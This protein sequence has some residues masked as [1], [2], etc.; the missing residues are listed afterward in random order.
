[1]ASRN[2]KPTAEKSSGGSQAKPSADHRGAP[3]GKG[4]AS[5]RAAGTGS[6]RK[7]SSRKGGMQG[8]QVTD[9]MDADK[10]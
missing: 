1:M 2:S 8:N 5:P 6:T 7:Q 3:G 10:P 9:D 4:G